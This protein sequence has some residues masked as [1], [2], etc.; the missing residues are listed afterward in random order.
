MSANPLAEAGARRRAE[1]ESRWLT[2][3][4]IAAYEGLLAS[5]VVGSAWFDLWLTHFMVR[6]DSA[7]FDALRAA[8]DMGDSKWFLVTA[9]C[10]LL[11]CLML[12][13]LVTDPGVI[14]RLKW[15][16]RVQIWLIAAVA[17]SGI[18]A[19]VFKWIFGRARPAYL[20]DGR[21]AD[22]TLFN[23]DWGFQSYPS[24]HTT[25]L[26]SAAFVLAAVFP[27]FRWFIWGCA[28][29][30]GLGRIAHGAHF[31]SDVI[32]GAL[33]GGVTAW[34]LQGYLARRGVTAEPVR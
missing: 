26:F 25:T 10:W 12:T 20:E 30:G 6:T 24:G 7:L 19:N 16:V 27:R 34:W 17:V 1:T 5:A 23:S 2:R 31:L 21:A 3:W 33:L 14:A 11:G 4:Q 32:A 15:L 13:R 18:V 9:G 28:V 29:A 8:E 22:W